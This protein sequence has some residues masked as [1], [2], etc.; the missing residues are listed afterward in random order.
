[1][2]KLAERTYYALCLALGYLL[3]SGR[4][5]RTL[6]VS[7]GGERDVRKRRLFYAPLLV[8]MGGPLHRVLN[9]GVRV[10]P[11][12]EW[13][14]RERSM[15]QRLHGASIRIDGGTLTLPYLPGETLATL[16]ERRDLDASVRKRAIELAVIALA[17]LHRQGF[18]HGDA[19]AE[20]VMIDLEAGVARWFDFETMHESSRSTDWCRADDVRALLATC[21]LRVPPEQ[22]A[23]TVQR[24][25][26]R[27]GDEEMSRLVAMSF[28]SALRR[29]LAFHLGQAALSFQ[30]FQEFARLSRLAQ[31]LA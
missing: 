25:A 6:V 21:L 23:E 31:D 17:E 9:T 2:R 22:F 1:V 28:S 11:Q 13:T 16:L 29:P 26:G 7:R 24:V 12:R 15:Y 20:N 4:Y 8:W 10:L 19:M 27:Y 30:S 3:R 18:T 5:A 14:E